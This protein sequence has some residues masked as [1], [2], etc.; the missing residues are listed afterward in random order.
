MKDI[1][2]ESEKLSDGGRPLEGEAGSRSR[3]DPKHQVGR[4]REAR[5]GAGGRRL[6]GQRTGKTGYQFRQKSSCRKLPKSDNLAS[7]TA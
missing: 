6:R 5:G 2:N 4:R 3:Q 7:Q 1:S